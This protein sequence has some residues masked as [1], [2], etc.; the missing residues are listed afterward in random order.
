MDTS[1]R[2]F[3]YTDIAYRGFS[4]IN[5]AEAVNQD[6]STVTGFAKRLFGGG[7]A[8]AER[9]YQHGYSGEM[10]YYDEPDGEAY[11]EPGVRPHIKQEDAAQAR[12]LYRRKL[13]FDRFIGAV[14]VVVL[15]V[16]IAAGIQ[17]KQIAEISASLGSSS[18]AVAG[19]AGG[20]LNESYQLSVE[21]GRLDSD[22]QR[23]YT[24]EVIADIAEELG[25]KQGE[26]EYIG[27]FGSDGRFTAAE[28]N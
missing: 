7:T 17:A 1:A 4:A 5:K 3:N 9:K 28:G 26:P 21:N 27:K 20:I 11:S 2:H 22:L 25:M 8:V 14:V 15:A 12:L 16:F 24:D 19:N 18:P 6:G 13:A 10:P 23:K